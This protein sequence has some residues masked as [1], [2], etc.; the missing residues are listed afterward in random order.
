MLAEIGGVVASV[1]VVVGTLGFVSVLVY[2][3]KI[4]RISI[5]KYDHDYKESTATRK[6]K[7]TSIGTHKRDLLKSR[8]L[9]SLD[10]L[11]SKLTNRLSYLGLLT[12]YDSV[13][14]L[15]QENKDV[16]I[17]ICSINNKTKLI[18]KRVK[19]MFKEMEGMNR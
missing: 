17:Q 9:Y 1:R 10:N 15:Q 3:Y 4:A 12:T 19:M 11:S 5:I 14:S 8:S 18:D 6:S 7:Y 16:D 2:M 13:Q